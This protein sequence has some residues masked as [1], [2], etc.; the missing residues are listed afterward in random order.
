MS[1]VSVHT[2]SI[3]RL[4]YY[5]GSWVRRLEDARFDEQAMHVCQ[6]LL[7]KKRYTHDV[8]QLFQIVTTPYTG[9]ISK[10]LLSQDEA[11]AGDLSLIPTQSVGQMQ[12]E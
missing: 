12:C 10:P 4:I 1:P 9:A 5:Y 8:A 11:Q 2:Y 7:C 6:G 3:A